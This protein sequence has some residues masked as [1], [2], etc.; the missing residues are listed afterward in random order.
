M[1][2]VLGTVKVVLGE[3]EVAQDLGQRA[4]P[5]LFARMVWG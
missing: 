4:L 5:D 1:A 2:G 3:A